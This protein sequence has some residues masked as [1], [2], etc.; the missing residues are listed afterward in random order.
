MKRFL[1]IVLAVFSTLIFISYLFGT[2]NASASNT[3]NG[4]YKCSGD[5]KYTDTDD[6]TA[7][8]M[9]FYFAADHTVKFA[10]PQVTSD[11]DTDDFGMERLDLVL[12]SISEMGPIL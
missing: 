10:E 9:Y 1:G 8:P 3:L 5:T 6:G 4:I 12:G 11:N 2:M 7:Q